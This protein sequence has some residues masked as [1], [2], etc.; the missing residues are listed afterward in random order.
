MVAVLESCEK[1][2]SKSEF[3]KNLKKKKEK[4]SLGQSGFWNKN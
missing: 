1:L 2:R 3:E 4:I